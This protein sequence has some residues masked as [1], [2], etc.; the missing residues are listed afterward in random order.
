MV[1]DVDLFGG[2]ADGDRPAV[3]PAHHHALEERLAAVVMRR[4]FGG[5]GVGC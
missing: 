4:F 1:L 5:H 2:P 3:A